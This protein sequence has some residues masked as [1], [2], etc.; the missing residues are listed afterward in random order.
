MPA[1]LRLINN[2]LWNDSWTFADIT[3]KQQGMASARQ[4]VIE[5]QHYLSGRAGFEYAGIES[6]VQFPHPQ[7][8]CGECNRDRRG[9]DLEF[10][11]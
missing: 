7:S 10:L 8:L 4:A 2:F 5:I 11:G 3:K 6:G 9:N 1:I